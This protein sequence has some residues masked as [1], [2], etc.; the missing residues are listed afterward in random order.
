MSSRILGP[1]YG[2]T[3]GNLMAALPE[4]LRQDPSVF[5]LAES[6]AGLL[7]GRPE[8]IDRLRIYPAIDALPEN[9]LD[10][11]AYDFKVDWWDPE[12]SLEEK[13]RTLKTSWK[14]HKTLGTK[15]AV[16]LALSAV[17]PG[18]EVEE[19]FEYDGK[20]YH[21]RVHVKVGDSEYVQSK[22][23]RVLDRIAWYKNLRSHLERIW[24]EM[25][26]VVFTEQ[27]TFVFKNFRVWIRVNQRNRIVLNGEHPLDGS[28]LLN[29]DE[30]SVYH[31]RTGIRTFA[32][33]PHR[34]G[35]SVFR[36]IGGIGAL[37][38]ERVPLN[39]GIGII[40]FDNMGRFVRLD[41][42]H[43][44]DGSWLLD[45]SPRVPQFADFGVRVQAMELEER[46]WAVA[47]HVRVVHRTKS[48]TGPRNIK[49]AVY[50]FAP[51]RERVS[52]TF[53]PSCASRVREHNAAPLRPY[54]DARI[55]AWAL[56][57]RTASGLPVVRLFARNNS[58]F[59]PVS[60]YTRTNAQE[61]TG[62]GRL[63]IQP[64]AWSFR[65][66]VGSITGQLE[67]RRRDRMD[68]KHLMDGSR[69]FGGGDR[70]VIQL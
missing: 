67:K 13:R 45:Q 25:P 16:E 5:A 32:R 3:A 62:G 27:E 35:P 70:E 28:W 57:H 24:Y 58:A 69:T 17:Y 34:L 51:A 64:S 30:S 53:M 49:A 54:L 2:L 46:L 19:W 21:F 52:C 33:M 68:G 12:Y 39:L 18:T 6:V 43:P 31:V 20:P 14:V 29:Q 50:P 65:N 22:H 8:E 42:R 38:R 9:L 48:R 23:K 26:L 7:A 61:E 59:R 63:H 1:E 40:V 10:I 4:A 37:T 15:A 56:G 41:G 44:L 36:S 66:P 60:T 11:L 47:S 55:Y